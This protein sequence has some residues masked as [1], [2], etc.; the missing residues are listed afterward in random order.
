MQMSAGQMKCSGFIFIRLLQQDTGKGNPADVLWVCSCNGSQ[1]F[2][3]HKIINPDGIPCMNY[4]AASEGNPAMAPINKSAV[5]RT[6]AIIKHICT[7][8]RYSCLD[9][10][11]IHFT[12][13][14]CRS[15][16]KYLDLI[17]D[18]QCIL[19]KRQTPACIIG[20]SDFFFSPFQHIFHHFGFIHL[21]IHLIN[22]IAILP[23]YHTDAYGATA[24][25]TDKPIKMP[26]QVSQWDCAGDFSVRWDPS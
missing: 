3:F 10:V 22:S 24:N 20:I 4:A 9:C 6:Q 7:P 5:T 23:F 11:R 16:A 17:T 14:L 25:P 1:I 12:G 8:F 19:H 2:D 15:S 13:F 21:F 26:A 18:L